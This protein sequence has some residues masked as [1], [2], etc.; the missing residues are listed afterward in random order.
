MSSPTI[1][2]V[3]DSLTARMKLK[4]LLEGDGAAVILAEDAKQAD[5]LAIEHRPE[6]I[7]L[8]VVLPDIDGIELCKQWCCNPVL[9]DTPVL[10]ISGERSGQDDRAAGMRAG[11]L[12]FVTKPFSGPELLAQVG[13]LV[14]LNETIREMREAREAA[15]AANRAKSE[16]LAK[17]SHELRTPLNSII[18]FTEMMIDDAKDPPNEK[19]ARRLE[20]VHRNSKNLLA[21]INDIL[22]ISKIE[23]DRLALDCG[24]VDVAAVIQECAESIRPLVKGD[25]VE[26]RRLIDETITSGFRW[27]GDAIRLTQI[28]T[29]LLSNAAKFTESGHIELRVKT[30]AG[31]LVIEVE[32]TGIGIAPDHLSTIFDE[33][34]QVD[35]SSTRRAGGTGLGLSICRKLCKLMGGQVT[36]ASTLG[37]GSCFTVI[38]PIQEPRMTM[39]EAGSLR[40]ENNAVLYIGNGVE[41][42][43]ILQ[44]VTTSISRIE[45]L[46]EVTQAIDRCQKH[47]PAMTWIDPFWADALRL[48]GDLKTH[49]GTAGIPFGLLG[50]MENRCAFVA[51]DDCLA[52][53]LGKDTL[54]RIV[55]GDREAPRHRRLL[56][57]EGN[58][59]NDYLRDM[60]T[61]FPDIEMIKAASGEQALGLVASKRFD[62]VLSDLTNTNARVF[63]L[64][65][66]LRTTSP[67]VAP[68]LVAVI[69][70]ESTP[71]HVAA[72]QAGFR[73]YLA[74]HGE[75]IEHVVMRSLAVV[76]SLATKCEPEEVTA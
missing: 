11:A 57:V 59:Q 55:H 70:R 63:E 9:K 21:L 58:T 25:R 69:P 19:R 62:A 5:A 33:F 64:V 24:K 10:L 61:E 49:R 51:F 15:D 6:A 66:R 28:V 12:G 29:N 4:E 50:M 36:A 34:E 71:G 73:Q 20:K 26:I 44:A 32:D 75:P 68:Q 8:D 1:L 65:H 22:D 43:R 67:S 35:S 39:P 2:V 16:F 76:A 31:S 48:L 17:M 23:A 41:A 54:R 53:P 72:F 47:R 7:V 74:R 40:H 13:M 3:D 46:S 37:I 18:G 52:P 38:L 27:T 56:M 14:H 45:C 60:L 42:Q 30:D